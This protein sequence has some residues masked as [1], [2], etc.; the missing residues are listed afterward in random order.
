MIRLLILFGGQSSEHTVSR[1][2]TA[3]L[4]PNIDK[5]RLDATVVG[6]TKD[7]RWYLTQATPDEIADGSWEQ[8]QDNLPAFLSPNRSM[9]GLQVIRDGAIESIPVDVVYPVMH[10]ELAEDGALQGLF[11]LCGL[12]YVGPD[13]C[14]SAC[15]MD[16]AVTKLVAASSGVRQARYYLVTKL[17]YQEDVE[18]ELD[19]VENAFTGEYPLFVKPASAGS[20]VGVS[21]AHDRK[22]LQEAIVTALKVCAKVLIEETIIGREVEVAVMGN[23]DPKTSVVGEVLAANEFY[24]FNAKYENAASRTVIPANISDEASEKL[25]S[26]AVK[27]YQSLGCAGMSRVDFFLQEDG[28]IVFNEI[29]T[30]PGFTKISMY[31]MLWGATGIPYGDLLVKLCE[32]AME[33]GCYFPL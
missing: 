19:R 25:R 16:K 20:S 3:S 8:R 27:V 11:E 6:I 4:I 28:D 29:N 17:N 15:S 13:I 22:E 26:A 30:L 32:I 1:N 12:P 10:G 5:T 14:A 31:P 24:D 9:T 18:K 33:K 21:K 7:G 23:A 2:S